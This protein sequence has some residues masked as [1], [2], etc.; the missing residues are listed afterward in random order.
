MPAMRPTNLLR[1]YTFHGTVQTI[2]SSE[3][4]TGSAVSSFGSKCG[5]IGSKDL[6]RMSIRFGFENHLPPGGLGLMIEIVETAERHCT[7]RI[8]RIQAETPGDGTACPLW[9]GQQ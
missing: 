8:A 7:G 3:A 2:L 6:R 4:S 9:P 1:T 5:I